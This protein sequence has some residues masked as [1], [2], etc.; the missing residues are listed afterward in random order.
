M[1]PILIFQFTPVLATSTEEPD[2]V[3]HAFSSTDPD[4]TATQLYYDACYWM[5]YQ[6][7][8]PEDKDTCFG[9]LMNHTVLHSDLTL[10][11]RAQGV[12]FVVFDNVI[13][14]EFAIHPISYQYPDVEEDEGLLCTAQHHELS[15]NNE[16][17][18]PPDS[19]SD[20]DS[21]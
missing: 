2:S 8:H 4:R 14:T 18:I 17:V 1:P 3:W 20:S 13:N 19:D 15:P 10:T 12:Q 5:G 16:L 7:S 21:D 11:E 9:L 6:I